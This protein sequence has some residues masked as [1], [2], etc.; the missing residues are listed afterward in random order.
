MTP[1]HELLARIRWDPAFGAA[2]F[3]IGYWHRE[4]RTG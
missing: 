3:V 4:G 1:V 2:K